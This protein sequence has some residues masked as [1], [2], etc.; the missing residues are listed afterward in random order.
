[1]TQNTVSRPKSPDWKRQPYQEPAHLG[2]VIDPLTPEERNKLSELDCEYQRL[3][4]VNAEHAPDRFHAYADRLRTS[5]AIDPANLENYATQLA[6]ARGAYFEMRLSSKNAVARFVT[7]ECVPFALP[8]LK[9]APDL[10]QAEIDAVDADYGRHFTSCGHCAEG[11]QS[12]IASGFRAQKVAVLEEIDRL[13]K[14]WS[15][16]K[17]GKA[18][19]YWVGPKRMLKSVLRWTLPTTTETK[20]GK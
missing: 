7:T 14:L 11:K 15:E 13:E 3:V 2:Y 17:A 6:V 8:I 1:M 10:I 19:H 20:E 5:A 16:H 4:A 9:R 12:P 18:P